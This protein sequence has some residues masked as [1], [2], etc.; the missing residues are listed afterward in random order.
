MDELII[1]A[2]HPDDVPGLT[3]LL[4][5]PGVRRGTLRVPYTRE[6]AIRQRIFEAGP[7][8]HWLVGLIEDEVVAQAGLI[9]KMA[10]QAHCGEVLIAVHD[11]HV[12]RGIGRRMME[13]ML[14][15]ADNWLGLV[16]VQ[17]D[18]DIDNAPA[19]HLYESVGFEHEGTLRAFALREGVLIDAHMMARL[20]PAPRRQP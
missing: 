16:R 19:I 2:P 5:L 14:D 3:A 4:N 12:G 7:N 17:L 20:R 8:V 1:R 13:A 11:D 15:L 18:V 9:R 10:R 6:D